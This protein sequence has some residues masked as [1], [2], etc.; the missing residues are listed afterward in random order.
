MQSVRMLNIREYNMHRPRNVARCRQFYFNFLLADSHS[1]VLFHSPVSP[2]EHP[3]TPGTLRV[4]QSIFPVGQEH[5][6]AP[7]TSPSLDSSGLGCLVP[8]FCTG[9]NP[10][11]LH[12]RRDAR[13]P[14][15]PKK[16]ARPN[17]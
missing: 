8:Y 9:V 1:I 15:P 13:L 10:A 7:P 14:P 3:H 4:P 16:H 5:C 17:R 2:D 6:L 11:T 12:Q